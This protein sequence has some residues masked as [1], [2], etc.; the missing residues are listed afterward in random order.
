MRGSPTDKARAVAELT[1]AERR[2]AYSVAAA[3]SLFSVV[4]VGGTY[5]ALPL[6]GSTLGASALVRLAVGCLLFVLIIRGQVRRIARSR[7]PE[8]DAIESVVLAAAVFLAIYATTY[9]SVSKIHPTSFSK[10][11]D[12]TGA[13]YFAITTFGTVGYGDIAARSHLAEMLVSSQ[14]LLDLIFLAAIVRLLFGASRRA[15]VHP[16]S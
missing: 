12:R 4:V 16:S 1:R 11:L 6:H 5:F 8:L 15:L 10:P 9:A 14:I 3:R 13:L 7:L 2:R